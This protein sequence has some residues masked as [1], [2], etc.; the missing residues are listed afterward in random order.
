MDTQKIDQI[1]NEVCNNLGG[2]WLLI[3]GS[4]VQLLKANDRATR[5]IDLVPFDASAEIDPVLRLSFVQMAK[6][7][8]L[9][10]TSINHSAGFFVRQFHNWESQTKLFLSGPKGKVFRPT[11]TL[12]L[13]LKI[14]RATEV[15]ISDC[16]AYL[17]FFHEETP[18]RDL[19]RKWL[20]AEEEQKL[21]ALFFS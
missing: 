20:S 18:D 13:A 10:A 17:K 7:L 5:D 3:G 21:S 15:D 14:K 8:G 9:V 11:T 19:L 6:K 1:L 2:D 12:F 16:H 4:L